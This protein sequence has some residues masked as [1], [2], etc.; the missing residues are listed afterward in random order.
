MG[1]YL[2]DF[3]EL[4]S[5]L[6]VLAGRRFDF[7]DSSLGNLHPDQTVNN[8]SSNHFSPRVGIVYQPSK[9]TSLYFNWFNSFNPQFQS[10]SRTD[11]Q[12]KPETAEQFEVG[13]KQEL[14]NNQ[15]S[16][17]L[18]FYQLTRQNVLTTDPVDT[19]FSI[20]TGEQISRGI[21]ADPAVGLQFLTKAELLAGWSN[22]AMLL[23]E[24]HPDFYQAPDNRD[25]PSGFVR[26]LGRV[27]GDRTII[28]EVVLLNL[29]L[30]VLSLTSPFLIQILTDDVLIR[31][32]RQLS[33]S[34]IIA[35]LTFNFIS[36]G[37]RYVQ[38]NLI[39][40]I[41]QRLELD[42]ILEFG[43]TILR[44]PLPYYEAR[45]SGEVVSRVRDI[46]EINQLISQV[47]V[48]LPSQFFIAIVSLSFMCFHSWKLTAV[49][50]VI[51]VVLVVATLA[52]LPSIR[53]KIQN[54]LV[55]GSENQAV[56]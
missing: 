9:T 2:Q 21:V 37:L 35:V 25:K 56:L 44:L 22:G 23:V 47:G 45:R 30:G 8:Q 49:P 29:A 3:I 18:A 27:W 12:F 40:H 17:T 20:Q 52:L 19:A 10:R 32:D 42:M 13:V 4:L 39:A 28:V 36:S 24:P 5:N 38:S 15:V 14:F 50:I 51:A 54:V 7:N 48:T 43:R 1:I 34:V 33:T 11:E 31:R 53:K 6:K 41:A 26:L 46:Q 55:V 16:A